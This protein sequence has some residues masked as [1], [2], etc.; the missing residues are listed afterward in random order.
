MHI[1]NY[2]TNKMTYL[3]ESLSFYNMFE[4][5][6]SIIYYELYV[7]E[8]IKTKIPVKN[9]CSKIKM[10]TFFWQPL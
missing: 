10:I 6:I 9:N 4:L 8:K 1:H 3:C 5:S 2:S 7:L